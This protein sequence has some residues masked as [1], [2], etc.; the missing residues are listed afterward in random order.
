MTVD[1]LKLG[2][3]TLEEQIARTEGEINLAKA[4]ILHNNENIARYNDEKNKLALSDESAVA[5]KA[6]KQ[7]EIT[8][9]ENKAAEIKSQAD[10]ISEKLSTLIQSSESISRQLESKAMEL[11]EL[12]LQLSEYRVSEVTSRSSIAEIASRKEAIIFAE[13]EKNA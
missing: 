9:L 6:K 13:N 12:S 7:A 3:A 2:I 11:N 8:D 10:T 1:E 4:N 5:E